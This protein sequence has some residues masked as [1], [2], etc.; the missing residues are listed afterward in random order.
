V[1]NLWYCCL[2]MC[3]VIELPFGGGEWGGAEEWCVRLGSRSPWGM[4][5]F[6]WGGV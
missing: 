3:E 6:F 1:G 5:G 2:K 4:G